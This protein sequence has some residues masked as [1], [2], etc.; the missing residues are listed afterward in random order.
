MNAYPSRT[1]SGRKRE[2]AMTI[3]AIKTL[4][5]RKQFTHNMMI[6]EIERRVAAD[7]M[8]S[9]ILEKGM[10]TANNDEERKAV[11]YMMLNA[12][13]ECGKIFA[14]YLYYQMRD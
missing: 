9:A 14:A 5:E 12:N 2:R 8:L 1:D 13:E 4:C 11:M 3:A 6:D 7:E 10:E